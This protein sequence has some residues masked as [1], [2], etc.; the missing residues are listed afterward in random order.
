M[1]APLRAID[2]EL[3]LLAWILGAA[4]QEARPSGREL[5]TT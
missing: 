3:G 4:S 2:A 5:G 1:F